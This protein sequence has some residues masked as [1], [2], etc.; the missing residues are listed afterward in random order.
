ML[1]RIPPIWRDLLLIVAPGVLGWAGQD[2]VPV[3]QHE[4]PL[5]GILAGSLVTAL[6][7]TLTRVTTLYGRGKADP[8]K[9]AA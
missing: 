3:L 9:H 1:D 6:T 2:V 4:S 5:Y 8:P 7:T